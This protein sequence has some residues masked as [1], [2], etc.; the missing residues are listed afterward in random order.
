VAFQIGCD[1]RERGGGKPADDGDRLP[2]AAA[3]VAKDADHAVVGKLRATLRL[4]RLRTALA[5]ISSVGGV[6]E[7]AVRHGASLE[8]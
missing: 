8:T 7:P 4:R 1:A 5:V 2:A 6:H 3:F